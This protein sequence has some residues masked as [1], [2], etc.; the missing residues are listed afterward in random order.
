MDL[1]PGG[2]DEDGLEHEEVY[3]RSANDP[4]RVSNPHTSEFPMDGS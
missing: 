3:C 2:G 1:Q 4:Q